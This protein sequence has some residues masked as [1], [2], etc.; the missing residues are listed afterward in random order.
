MNF[1]TIIEEQENFFDTKNMHRMTSDETPWYTRLLTYLSGTNPEF[2][3]EMKRK[4]FI[5]K[6]EEFQ[7]EYAVLWLKTTKLVANLN[8]LGSQNYFIVLFL[9]T[10]RKGHKTGM[11][12]EVGRTEIQ[13]DSISPVFSRPILLKKLEC[14]NNVETT[15]HWEEGIPHKDVKFIKNLYFV[16]FD[17]A[18]GSQVT[19]SDIVS[20]CR[21]KLQSIVKPANSVYS[22]GLRLGEYYSGDLV[23]TSEH[24]H[25][26]LLNFKV[27]L[28]ISAC[29]LKGNYLDKT[30]DPFL[31]VER[32]VQKI[33]HPIYTSEPCFNNSSPYWKDVVIPL[34]QWCN[35]DLNA[36]ITF[37]VYDYNSSFL[38]YP[39]RYLGEVEVPTIELLNPS[40]VDFDLYN[41]KDRSKTGVLQFMRF[42]VLDSE[43]RV[44]KDFGQK[45]MEIKSRKHQ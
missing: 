30:A 45:L 14:M 18:N 21:T 35:E 41:E 23:V 32:N 26:A 22:K 1:P 24:F 20:Y 38:L 29:E 3:P 2:I 33:P 11:Y 43:N 5:Q 28:R 7:K 31:V 12:Y 19:N 42:E 40:R 6:A 25:S 9:K 16:L 10:A 13:N 4:Q 17:V 37:K 39:H 44:V 34:Y 27:R 8:S 15:Y 36:R